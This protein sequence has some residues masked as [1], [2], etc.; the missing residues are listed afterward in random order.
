MKK[1][2][3][4]TI[5][6]AAASLM[7]LS[8]ATAFADPGYY[9]GSQKFLTEDLIA[10]PSFKLK[11]N[12]AVNNSAGKLDDMILD[13]D[14]F[15]RANY[16]QFVEA[17][18][19]GGMDEFIAFAQANPA[20]V[21]GNAVI[22]HPDN[23]TE[24]DPDA[25]VTAPVV[26]D[27]EAAN[28][29]TVTVT[30]D[31]A[32]AA[33]ASNFSLADHNVTGVQLSN[34]NKTATLSLGKALENTILHQLSITNVTA[35]DG[36]VLVAAQE[37]VTWI[38]DISQKAAVDSI[39]FKN[40]R[41]IQVKFNSVVDE[42]SASDPANYYFEIIDGNAAYGA[43][44]I[45]LFTAPTL[46]DSNQLSQIETTFDGGAAE[47]WAPENGNIV[48]NSSLGY[49]V[50][51]IHLP[52]D[53]RFTNVVD[54]LL[55]GQNNDVDDE[56]TLTIKQEFSNRQTVIKWLTKNVDVNVAVRNVRDAAGER[57]IDTYVQPI[58]ILDE[59][60]PT[61]EAVT[62][63][64]SNHEDRHEEE[65][66][67]GGL[68]VELGTYTLTSDGSDVL[69]F[70]YSEPVFD[71]HGIDQSDAYKTR[72]VQVVVN[73]KIVG[74]TLNGNLD[75][76]LE[77]DMEHSAT[78][79]S[80]RIAK[81]NVKRA[82]E[83]A[84]E[85]Y[86][87]GKTFK[88]EI[89]G[90]TD[91][92]GN[93]EVQSSHTLYVNLTD[94]AAVND[95]K[96][97][98]YDI[99]QVADNVFRVEFNRCGA[100]GT[101]VIKNA[102]GEGGRVE[103]CIPESELF[104]DEEGQEKYYSYVAVNALDKE[105]DLLDIDFFLNDRV[106]AYDGQDFIM[107]DFSI[108][109]VTA[110][111]HMGTMNGE[112]YS[113]NNMT[114]YNDIQAPVALQPEDVS[115]ADR[116]NKVITVNVK[117]VVPYLFDDNLE[118][119]VDAVKYKY[120]S[121]TKMFTNKVVDHHGDYLPIEVS[122]VD[123]QGATH[124][125]I[126]SNK[127]LQLNNPGF[128]PDNIKYDAND[129]ELKL[130]LSNYPQLL[131]KDPA[132]TTKYTLV[133][134]ATYQISIPEGYFT[135]SPRELDFHHGNNDFRDEGRFSD[136][137]HK[138]VL[139]VDAG[140]SGEMWMPEDHDL[141]PGDINDETIDKLHLERTEDGIG[142]T[143]A[144]QAL[145]FAVEAKPI[146][147]DDAVP[148]TSFELIRF[149]A[150]KNEL[151]VEFTG[152][153][154]VDTLKDPDN[155]ILDGTSLADWGLTSDDITYLVDNSNLNNIRQYA[156]FKVPADSVS[157]DGENV[158][159]KVQGVTNPAGATMTPVETTVSLLDNTRPQVAEARITGQFEI[160]LT[161]DEP[162]IYRNP[163]VINVS[164]AAAHNFKVFDG[165]GNEISVIKAVAVEIH[166]DGKDIGRDVVLTTAEI[167]TSGV[168]TVKVVP[169]QNGN[170]LII[171][172]AQNRN[173]LNDD[174]TYTATRG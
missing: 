60:R 121:T 134:G 50:V 2:I 76:Y 22:I 55:K 126:V 27:A 168:V 48:A 148:Q 129:L 149:D 139:Y 167:P 101:F 19:K 38:A 93:I 35:A 131:Q 87:K 84:R 88:I 71:A 11:L 100:T 160:K 24:P 138:N 14:E 95:I 52:E 122:Y 99:V 73:G 152:K 94:P 142:Y 54:Q 114:L 144:K 156:V 77:F 34:G 1:T 41:H 3:K 12:Q 65:Q 20:N 63:V 25:V 120:D 90:V 83:A 158:A 33:E 45:P 30:F 104:I 66:E 91:L 49:T 53:A 92:A 107:R 132:D 32:V 56:R 109:D 86:E 162:V 13:L 43:P 18:P 166:E 128:D 153:I 47:Y 150:P 163:D 21:P 42:I 57:T 171:D 169:D 110:T 28:A 157:I 108:S 4:K 173:P 78:Y 147:K 116:F 130:D 174:I 29:T 10:D 135:D 62:V 118:H 59:V 125:A 124:K 64:Q 85:I 15:G 137:E 97:V 36:G 115:Y 106:L 103:A 98:V 140:R 31:K 67:D 89:I 96:P 151:A 123:A 8:P 79:D 117:D 136:Y 17:Y 164:E 70:E 105:I 6:I 74:T 44:P 155:Y 143:S 37:P 16:G 154:D 82:V 46:K 26:I 111:S 72:N 172:T 58:R 119:P 9:V 69:A 165:D 7:L 159:F 68:P 145:E 161:F 61:L 113:K 75:D 5:A 81:L 133:P 112:T 146:V 141:D 51:D 80:A 102:D 170:I 40:Y 39:T 23:S 127:E